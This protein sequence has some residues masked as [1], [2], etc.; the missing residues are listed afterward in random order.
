MTLTNKK[1]SITAIVAALCFGLLAF[2]PYLLNITTNLL[3]LHDFGFILKN[4]L[5][6]F[7]YL[8]NSVNFIACIVMAVGLFT[9]F[10]KIA[11]SVSSGLFFLSTLISVINSFKSLFK[12]SKFLNIILSFVSNSS[13]LFAYFLFFA[14]SLFL[15]ILLFNKKEAP[16]FF[17]FLFFVPVVILAITFFLSTIISSISIFSSLPRYFNTDYTVNIIIPNIWGGFQRLL[18][19]IGFTAVAIKLADLKKKPKNT[20]EISEEIIIENVINE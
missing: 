7:F 6:S 20:V 9:K 15:A 5:L 8:G 12:Y 2:Q 11:V 3:S 16:K 1:L 4:I 13:I 17:K 14:L 19:I 18:L 10:D